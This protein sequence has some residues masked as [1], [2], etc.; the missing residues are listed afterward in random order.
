VQKLLGKLE[1]L[2]RSGTVEATKALEEIA[3]GVGSARQSQ[4]AQAALKRLLLL[5][6]K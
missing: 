5:S 4:V 6:G 3:Q 1:A 2:E